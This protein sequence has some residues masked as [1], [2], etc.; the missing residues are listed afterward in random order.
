MPHNINYFSRIGFIALRFFIVLAYCSILFVIFAPLLVQLEHIKNPIANYISTQLNN[1]VHFQEIQIRYFPRPYIDLNQLTIQI[2]SQKY[3]KIESVRV[4]PKL[5]ELFKGNF[6]IA[7]IQVI[8]P[9]FTC[10]STTPSHNQ[11]SA[12]LEKLR[13]NI[14]YLASVFNIQISQGQ[15]VWQQNKN[16]LEFSNINSTLNINQRDITI[17]ISG[18]SNFCESVE[19]QYELIRDDM[20]GKGSLDIKHLKPNAILL[21]LCHRF[22]LP[23]YDLSLNLRAELNHYTTDRFQI[24]CS[25]FLP[26]AEFYDEP[27]LFQTNQITS[28][29]EIILNKQAITL[30]INQLQVTDPNLN[31]KGTWHVDFASH[32]HS[33]RLSSDSLD[34]DSVKQIKCVI[35]HRV[36]SRILDIVQQ[37]FIPQLSVEYKGLMSSTGFNPKALVLKAILEQGLV[38]VPKPMLHLDQVYGDVLLSDG[39]LEGKNI[40]AHLGEIEGERGTLQLALLFPKKNFHVE[41]EFKGKLDGLFTELKPV[42]RQDIWSRFI[43]HVN[44]I[45]GTATGELIIDK[46]EN[47]F[48]LHAEPKEMQVDL[49]CKTT[50]YCIRID[51]GS[52]SVHNR[53][54]FLNQFQGH[55]GISEF[56]QLDAVLNFQDK[57]NLKITCKNALVHSKDIDDILKKNNQF[58]FLQNHV[59]LLDGL[60]RVDDLMVD[61]AFFS[62]DTWKYSMRGHLDQFNIKTSHTPDSIKINSA[63]VFVDEHHISMQKA[64]AQILDSSMVVNGDCKG[65]LT[66]DETIHIHFDATAGK[67]TLKWVAQQFSFTSEVQ[68][69]DAITFTGSSI[70]WFP[71]QK[72]FTMNAICKNDHSKFGLTIE[73]K[74]DSYA[75]PFLSIKDDVSNAKLQGII[76]KNS[77]DVSFEGKLSLI[78]LNSFF[79]TWPYDSGWIQGKLDIHVPLK[80]WIPTEVSGEVYGHEIICRNATLPPMTIHRFIMNGKKNQVHI[81]TIVFSLWDDQFNVKGHIDLDES[82]K[83]HQFDLILQ[84]KKL[85][86]SSVLDWYKQTHNPE[87]VQFRQPSVKGKLKLEFGSVDLSKY[88]FESVEGLLELNSKHMYLDI[89]KAKLCGISVPVSIDF[90]SQGIDIVVKPNVKAGSIEEILHCINPKM[91]IGNGVLQLDS[92]FSISDISIQSLHLPSG[93]EGTFQVTA[94]NGRIYRYNLLSKLF[95]V[96]NVTELFK[97]RFTELVENGFTF[98]EAQFNGSIHENR[99]YLNQAILRG[100]SVNIACEG[101]IDLNTQEINMLF[102]VAPFVSV[103]FVIQHVPL[104]NR[105]L[106]GHLLTIPLKAVGNAS[107]PNIIPIPPTEVGSRIK[108]MMMRTLQLPMTIIQPLIQDN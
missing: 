22:H 77:I 64:H 51:K 12:M 66:G 57:P 7:D 83:S 55:Y 25:A 72:K 17:A 32:V 20:H 49:F 80:T 106:D 105:I 87:Q 95:M 15:F 37:G 94:Q 44:D 103:D 14:S 13:S 29:V 47:G 62:K 38:V 56:S 86:L 82:S 30:N 19:M 43:T 104:L 101:D 39:V 92:Q 96:L 23:V 35:N 81:P 100:D 34:I 41:C 28:D 21:D 26:F 1:H 65:Y 16:S 102:L 67:D 108:D 3:G 59:T 84:G 45:Q 4:F 2:D 69:N 53:E 85:M 5:S 42:F 88:H 31:L 58:S 54:F 78:T 60:L 90:S 50:P 98:T 71:R 99:L 97:S 61:G 8:S 18:N 107:D 68:L 89:S 76:H 46:N 91:N 73:K 52:V 24:K 11:L 70:T 74:G 27:G 79:K 33:F 75:I 36:L 48:W 40:R 10:V 63:N 9:Q 93:F 6:T